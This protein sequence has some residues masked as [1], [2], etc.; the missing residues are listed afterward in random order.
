MEVLEHMH[1]RGNNRQVQSSDVGHNT[2]FDD[3]LCSKNP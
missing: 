2:F 3:V 1:D